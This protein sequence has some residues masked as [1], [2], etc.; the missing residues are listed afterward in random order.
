[1]L[2]ELDGVSLRLGAG[3]GNAVEILR[4]ISFG[5]DRG[6][7]FVLIGPSG[8]GKSSLLRLIN[9]LQDPSGGRILLA[10]EDIQSLDVISLRRRCA[11]VF[12]QP[13]PLP[14]T[15]EENLLTGPSLRGGDLEAARDRIPELLRRVHLDPSLRERRAE[16]LSVGQQ[17]R[18]ALARTLMN[19]PEVLLLDEPT[20]ALDPGTST[21]ILD[22]VTELNQ[23]LGLTLIMVTHAFREAR[24]LAT[25]AG[26]IIDGC[27]RACGGP[28]ILRGSGDPEADRFL[29]QD[30]E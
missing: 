14:G 15:V 12:Q 2:I 13:V 19:E 26:I 24:R 25:A 27:L 3:R 29:K 30:E 1:M 5:V 10:G 4:D 17:H 9:K 11:M 21:A 22:L 6:D 20:A 28:E 23:E 18:V 7:R 8:A 16:D